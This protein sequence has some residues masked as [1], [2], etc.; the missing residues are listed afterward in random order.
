MMMFLLSLSNGKREKKVFEFEFTRVDSFNGS[1][2]W[3]LG[4]LVS[5]RLYIFLDCHYLSFAKFGFDSSVLS[6]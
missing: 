1:L 6:Y 2:F 5:F 3:L 4:W